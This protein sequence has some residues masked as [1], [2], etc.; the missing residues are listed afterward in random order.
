MKAFRPILSVLLVLLLP[1]PDMP[2]FAATDSPENENQRVVN[3]SVITKADPVWLRCRLSSAAQKSIS[4]YSY[5]FL[6]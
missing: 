1:V 3:N 5:D 6:W 4:C 2:A